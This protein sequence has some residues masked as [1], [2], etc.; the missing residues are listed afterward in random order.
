[1]S[2]QLK[3]N[4]ERTWVY[5]PTPKIIIKT[6]INKRINVEELKKA[7]DKAI[8]VNELL[9]CRITFDSKQ[10]TYYQVQKHMDFPLE[11]YTTDWQEVVKKDEKEPFRP[12][13]G[14]LLRF[15]YSLGEEC[16]ELLLIAHHLMGDGTSY[17]Y[18]IKD[19]L[20]AL[21]GKELTQKPVCLYSM[22]DL[23]KK[24]KLAL[25][26]RIMMK[27]LN[28]SFAKT[29][30]HFTTDEYYTMA[31]K[32]MEKTDTRIV[33]KTFTKEQF[34]QMKQYG[35][36]NGITVNTL[37]VTALLQAAKEKSDIGH[38]VSIRK[39][40]YEGMGNFATGVSTQNQYDPSKTFLGN[41]MDF[42]KSMYEKL[43]DEKK[44]YFLLQFMGGITGSLQD[45]IYFAACDG[46][47]NKTAKQ[48]ANMFGYM[49]TPKGISV[50]NLTKLAIPHTYGDLELEEFTFVPPLVLNSKRIIGIATLGETMTIT[51]H[52]KKDAS[53]EENVA[54]FQEAMHTLEFA[55]Y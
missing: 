46:Y 4:K 5:S 43:N 10:D 1:M 38:A 25:P 53:E 49:G 37:I 20:L 31:K 17:A 7:I 54:F 40:G 51:L 32:Y 9:R 33:V 11:E 24:S 23:P 26:M 29:G 13:K 3:I 6:R 52:I 19:I 55:T 50:T 14:S 15:Y 36:A 44:K 35:K 21:T 8:Q 28:R 47:E 2:N 22:E 48:F 16:T 12:E 18:L 27:F 39:K 41:A 42:Q 34:Q 45:A 30:K